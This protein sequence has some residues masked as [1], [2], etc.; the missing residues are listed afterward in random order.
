MGNCCCKIIKTAIAGRSLS[1]HP[2]ISSI[3]SK[4]RLSHKLR[5]RWLEGKQIPL[6]LTSFPRRQPRNDGRWE[7]TKP[8]VTAGHPAGQRTVLCQVVKAGPWARVGD[9]ASPSLCEAL[10]SILSITKV[11]TTFSNICN[12]CCASKL[13]LSHP[14]PESLSWNRSQVKSLPKTFHEFLFVCLF[15]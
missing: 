12:S 5:F 6:I 2:C 10:N 1:P 4:S 11:K 14:H 7:W 9:R 3:N 13:W 8:G 15:V